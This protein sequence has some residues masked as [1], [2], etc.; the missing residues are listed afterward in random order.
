M[1]NN[2]IEEKEFD[3]KELGYKLYDHKLVLALFLLGFLCLGL[4]YIWA[5]RPVFVSDGL[6][7]VEE[8]SGGHNILS[9]EMNEMFVMGGTGA[10][11]IEIIKSRMVLGKVVEELNLDIKASPCFTPVFGRAMHKHNPPKLVVSTFEVPD[12][13]RGRAF[14]L[15]NLGEGK[16]EFEYG[17]KE[18]LNGRAGE[19]LRINISGKDSVELFVQSIRGETGQEFFLRKRSFLSAVNSLRSTLSV[20]E[21]KGKSGIL[22]IK[23][24]GFDKA[25]ITEQLNTL[26]R[27]YLRQNVERKSAEAENTLVFLEKQLPILKGNLDEAET[28]YNNYRQE[29]G[30]IDLSE[31]SHLVLEQVVKLE[32]KLFEMK[33]NQNKLNLRYKED[34]PAIVNFNQL[35]DKTRDKISALNNR[36]KDLPNTQQIMLQ[37]KRDV[38]VNMVLY[39]SLLNSVQQLKIVKAGRI[40]NVRILDFAVKPDSPIKPKKNRI[41]LLSLFLGLMAGIGFVFLKGV[42]F[43]GMTDAGKVEALLEAPLH[44]SVPKTSFAGRGKQR[45]A[46]E[47][48]IKNEPEG[49]MAEAF[50]SLRTSL[51]FSFSDRPA[52]IVC[53]TGPT[54]GV[55][56]SFV[57]MNFAMA[58]A[59]VGKRVLLVDCDLRQGRLH[60]LAYVKREPGLSDILFGKAHQPDCIKPF[61]FDGVSVVTTGTIPPNPSE[62][63]SH[64]FFNKWLQDRISEYDIVIL[65]SPPILVLSD[66]LL[67]GKIADYNLLVLEYEKHSEQDILD[68]RK[69][70]LASGVKIHGALFNKV[71]ASAANGGYRYKY[72]SYVRGKNAKRGKKRG[73]A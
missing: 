36:I 41:M 39:T 10:T 20:S 19:T 34:H 54:P 33:Q 55:G 44:A 57:S 24:T 67:I 7:Q 58:M 37:K 65:D 18:K 69:K 8:K 63:L 48:I 17:K 42:F 16:F 15:T 31:E 47:L 68:C 50:Y 23:I 25:A 11:E 22:S 5:A 49:I 1:E 26:L 64:D 32:E 9:P 56:K 6:V 70:C 72:Y 51:S 27:A 29:V 66:P 13:Y 43:N 3:L 52:N 4:F 21:A 14:K 30:S 35:I 46:N 71:K 60:A 73:T 53:V 45:N 62:L 12:A 38:S 2:H 61:D 40:G 28:L 59:K